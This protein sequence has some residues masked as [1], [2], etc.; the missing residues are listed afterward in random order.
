M[1][2][3]CHWGLLCGCQCADQGRC[4]LMA[5]GGE[6]VT[7]VGMVSISVKAWGC[8]RVVA[9][10]YGRALSRG[11]CLLVCM[12]CC[13]LLLD[14]NGLTVWPSI[15]RSLLSVSS[16]SVL[17]L[18][19]RSIVL[20]YISACCLSVLLSYCVLC[21]VC[22]YMVQP[23]F[24]RCLMI[25]AIRAPS[26][27][28]QLRHQATSGLLAPP[29]ARGIVCCPVSGFCFVS[30]LPQC[31]QMPIPPLRLRLASTICFAVLRCW[32]PSPRASRDFVGCGFT[33]LHVGQK[34]P[35]PSWIVPHLQSCLGTDSSSYLFLGAVRQWHLCVHY[36]GTERNHKYN[37]PK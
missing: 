31:S 4:L 11:W 7:I 37:T 10:P 28:L 20:I 25:A 14:G 3:D 34:M 6:F 26:L 36:I 29:S 27:L 32:L 13:C 9:F 8:L 33:G 18:F 21:A 35:G 1:F 12:Y 22:V 17:L 16:V 23:S 24:L 5:D 2:T 30:C 15:V 19:V